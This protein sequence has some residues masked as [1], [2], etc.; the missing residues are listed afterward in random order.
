M[1]SFGLAR[2]GRNA[3]LR[4]VGQGDS[5]CNL[6]LAFSFGR[7]DANGKRPTQWVD[8][9]L[10]GKRAEALAEHL[11][12]GQRVFVT[13]EDVHMETFQSR[14]RGEGTK[15]VGRVVSIEFAGDPPQQNAQAPAPAPRPAPS[16]APAPA[17]VRTGYDDMDDDI[18]F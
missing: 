1:Q 2:L 18:P 6:S 15:L 16:R 17:P 11:V 13:L 3:E 7:R 12:K 4:T 14:E 8:A 5:V 9:S 10:W